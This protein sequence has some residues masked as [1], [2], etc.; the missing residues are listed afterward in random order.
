MS[1]DRPPLFTPYFFL[2]C[3]FSF[4]VFFSVFFL[5]P[6]VPF[7]IRVMNN[8]HF[9][10]GNFDTNFI[11]QVFFKEEAGR[12]LANEEVALVTAAIQVFTEERKRSV[13][14]QPGE[15]AGPVSMWKYSTRPGI[16]KIG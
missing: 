3:G 8:R 6:T 10:E 12:K 13:A 7:H 1:T 11:E 16:R 14:Q 9:I 5:L 2:M 4:T 15:A